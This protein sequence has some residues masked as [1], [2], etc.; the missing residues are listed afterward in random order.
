MASGDKCSS[1]LEVG[2]TKQENPNPTQQIGRTNRRGR[3]NSAADLGGGV[4]SSASLWREGA[5]SPEAP[6]GNP[7]R[8]ASDAETEPQQADPEADETTPGDPL[9]HSPPP[10]GGLPTTPERMRGNESQG[11]RC[12]PAVPPR[13]TGTEALDPLSDPWIQREQHHQSQLSKTECGKDGL[14]AAE[15]PLAPASL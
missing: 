3:P 8:C 11:P 14:N 9:P 2:R 12:T 15:L 5:W 7:R 10:S 6:L 4:G 1:C 13:L